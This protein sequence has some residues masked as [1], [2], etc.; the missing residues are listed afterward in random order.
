MPM[1]PIERRRLLNRR[2]FLR[3]LSALSAVP[4]VL[5][6]LRRT[7]AAASPP[8]L[9]WNHPWIG[10]GHDFGENAWGHDGLS[11]NGWTVERFPDSRG[12]ID[13]EVV[14]GFGASG[15]GSLRI[16]ADL[17]G[18]HPSRARGEV[19]VVLTD[20]LAAPCPRG[21]EPHVNLEKVGVRCAVWLPPGSAGSPSAPNGVQFFFKTRVSEEQ[22]S[23]LYTAWQNIQP[24]W[25]GRWTTLTAQ[26]DTSGAAFV[27]PGF[28]ATRVSLVGLKIGINAESAATIQGP[29]YLDD[30]VLET[31]PPMIFDFEE[32]ELLTQFKG[33]QSVQDIAQG[34]LPVVRLFV[35][36]DGRA[37]PEFTGSG[38]VSGLDAV[39]FRDFDVLVDAA[40]RA[41]VWVMPV[42]LDFHWCDERRTV[43][44]V[45]LGGHADVIREP[46][47]RRTFLDVL[48]RVLQQY[49]HHPAIVAWDIINEP[50]W[51][52]P[53][54]PDRDPAEAL[55]VP[56]EPVPLADFQEFVRACADRVHRLT[57]DFVTVGSARRK[58]LKSWQ[59]LGLDFY[60]FHWYEKFALS[61]E[62]FP[63]PHASELGLDRPVV[64]GEVPRH[65]TGISPAAFIE[66]AQTQGYPALLF[67]SCRARDPFSGF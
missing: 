25:E 7:A 62:P 56:V 66:A 22:W 40:A 41:N 52:I 11:T 28:D 23:S 14:R 36:G 48:E 61:G 32:P 27:D 17:M 42:L 33:V 64:I 31:M 39:F 34:H 26:V 18:G 12:F 53:D 63:W 16:S 35:F 15:T 1:S 37:S 45:P 54:L 46:D 5:G 43:S 29:L 13:S 50:E 55:A 8:L 20:H 58:W 51:V 60:Q 21:G 2:E 49:G 30:Y 6:G 24:A 57:D 65:G 9:G 59:G 47:K 19:H 3:A 10:Y 38:H 67:W 4:P 44:D